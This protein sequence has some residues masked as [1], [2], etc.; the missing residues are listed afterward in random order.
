MRRICYISGTR[1][2]FGI[3][4][5]T[6]QAINDDKKL[7]LVVLVTGMHLLNKYGSTWKEITFNNLNIIGKIKVQLSGSDG[8][9]MAIA[10]GEQVI[11]FTKILQ[12]NKPDIL[13]L[14][15]DRGE[16][17]A[18]AIA[19]VHL[20]IPIV[21]IHGGEL[22]GTID[23][24]IR[25]SITKLAHFHFTSS[26]NS[27][28]RL[29]KMGENPNNIFVTGAPGLDEIRNITLV[30]QQLLFNKYQL[31]QKKSYFLFL[32]HPVVQQIASIKKQI[33]IIMKVLIKNDQ[34]ILI[35]LPNSD[36]GSS[37]IENIVKKYAERE[38]KIQIVV[39]AP[40]IDFLSLIAYAEV[41]VGN[42]SSGIIE[43]TSLGTPV[44]NLGDRQKFRERNLNTIDS[45]ISSEAI[46]NGLIE[47]LKMHNKSWN[48]CYGNGKSSSKIVRILK[49]LS[50]DSDILEK[51]NAY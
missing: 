29:I 4:R 32:F 6:L 18:G 28:N 33:E 31:N 8:R 1:A 47:C 42:S 49:N 34:Q 9:E 7:D 27:R 50:L 17:L 12:A 45:E 44:L 36:S 5:S 13:L 3:M 11:E 14:L 38:K 37:I 46:E 26:K 35:L 25:H 16:M 2:D 48:N 22:S 40:R 19:A 39:H 51:V 30:D 15:G 24:S 21:H 43:A 41:F 23:E 10:L 20:N